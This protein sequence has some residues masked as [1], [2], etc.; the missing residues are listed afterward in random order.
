MAISKNR[1]GRWDY[2]NGKKVPGQRRQAPDAFVPFLE[3]CLRRLADDP[4]L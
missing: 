1:Q 4:H 3:Y 2:L